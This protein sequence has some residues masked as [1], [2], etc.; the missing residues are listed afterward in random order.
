MER[1]V[2]VGGSVAGLLAARVLSEHFE[3]VVVLER[4]P[5]PPFGENRKGV[6]QGQHTHVLL[7]S[8]HD[9]LEGL[10]PGF[11]EGAARHGAV[12]ADAFGAARRFIG[13]A[14]HCRFE[15]G[16]RTLYLSRPLLEGLVRARV[17]ALANVRALSPCDALGLTTAGGRVTGVRLL[18]RASGSAEETLAADLVVDASGR[19]SRSPAWLEALGYP[20]PE[21]DWIRVQ[22][23]YATCTFRREQ[24]DLAAVLVGALPPHRGMGVLAALDQD[25]WMVSLVGYLGVSVPTDLSGFIAYAKS[26][27][28][29]AIFEVIRDAEALSAPVPARFPGSVRRR[30]ERLTRFPE[31]FLVTGDA[32]CAFNP[33]YGQGMSVAA[34]E[35]LALLDALEAGLDGLA[36]RF[37]RAAAS[38]LDTPWTL[39]AGNDL[40]FPEVEGTRKRSARAVNAYLNRYH[41][42]AAHDPALALAFG[43]VISLRASPASLLSPRLALR[44]LR[45]NLSPRPAPSFSAA[46]A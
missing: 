44:V 17:H 39:A 45:G 3:E 4:D 24:R 43:R 30:Y 12:L 35:A 10:F 22:G 46:R 42:A 19:G 27:P 7:S 15:S 23:A 36:P 20:K 34:Q 5:A 11:T 25:R 37:F 14:W 33:V 28:A 16:I 18:P 38:I 29:P 6:P 1:A 21:E 9:I 41:R 26:L 2:V 31:R 8:G 13:G 40:R 32:L